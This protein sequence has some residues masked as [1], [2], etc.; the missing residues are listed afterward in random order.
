MSS[1]S[2]VISLPADEADEPSIRWSCSENLYS[3]FEFFLVLQRRSSGGGGVE[4]VL[5][6]SWKRTEKKNQNHPLVLPVVLLQP[7]DPGLALLHAPHVASLGHLLRD[8]REDVAVLQ[9]AL[10][11]ALH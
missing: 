4:Q 11:G 3:N 6:G 5:V 1:M 10:Q 9:A 7:L 2:Y 8:L